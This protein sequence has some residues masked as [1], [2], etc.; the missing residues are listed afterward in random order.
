MV[1]LRTYTDPSQWQN[2]LG[3]HTVAQP[4]IYMNYLFIICFLY[5]AL[6]LTFSPHIPSLSKQLTAETLRF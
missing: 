6:A 5:S 3:I 2:Q 1:P 4:S